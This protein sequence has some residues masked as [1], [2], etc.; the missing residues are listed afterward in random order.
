MNDPVDILARNSQERMFRCSLC[1]RTVPCSVRLAFAQH[2]IT[3]SES[4]A[5]GCDPVLTSA[6]WRGSC[7]EGHPIREP[8]DRSI[9]HILENPDDIVQPDDPRFQT[10]Y[11]KQY[12]EMQRAK[13]KAKESAETAHRKKDLYAREVSE[14]FGQAGRDAL[15]VAD[16]R[17]GE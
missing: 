10:L 17:L 4:G 1:R 13:E 11:P 5:I 2:S 3:E 14:R 16:E 8:A 9:L 7:A 15:K 6:Y 12:E